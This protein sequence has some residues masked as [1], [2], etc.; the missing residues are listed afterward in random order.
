MQAITHI[1]DDRPQLIHLVRR[2]GGSA[3]DAVLDPV[4]K[5]FHAQ[6]IDGVIG[7]RVEYGC[8]LVYGDPV[9]APKD[10]PH[11]ATAFH[12]YC[13]KQKMSFIFLAASKNFSHWALNHV[14]KSSVEFGQELF[15]DPHM[16]PEKISGANGCLVRRKVKHALNENTNIFEYLSFDPT[17]EQALDQVGRAWLNGR[18]GPQIYISS[19]RLFADR[20]GKRWFYAKQND[21]IVGILVINRLQSKQGWLLNHL[22]VTPNA[23]NG[24]SELLVVKTIQA[25]AQEKCHYVTFGSVLGQ[26]VGKITGLGPISTWMANGIVKLAN[27]TFHLDGRRTFWE[28]FHPHSEPSYIL[29]SQSHVS[30]KNLLCLQRAL[31]VTL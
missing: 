9:C 24:T 3:T 30:L 17:L 15:L 7:Y 21:T 8:A 10:A 1:G 29:F 14:C 5:T 2:W 22:M 19:V 6:D 18:Q 23:P 25:L 16:D 4:C 31:N 12:R 11:L 28:K 27:K 20:I 26:E 13:Q